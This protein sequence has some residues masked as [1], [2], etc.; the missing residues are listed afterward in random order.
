MKKILVALL[1]SACSITLWAKDTPS[2]KQQAAAGGIPRLFIENKGQIRDQNR[3]DRK[4]IRFSL[5]T[6][7]AT[8]LFIGK[9]ALH[10]QFTKAENGSAKTNDAN[11]T[12]KKEQLTIY[13]MDV[14]LLGAN[15][16]APIITEGPGNYYEQYYNEQSEPDGIKALSFKKVIYKN[17]YPHIDWVLYSGDG[18]VKYEFLVHPGANVSD[19]RLQYEGAVGLA[20]QEDGSLR[21][22]TPLGSVVEQA[23]VS[24][25]QDGSKIPTAFHLEG[26]LLTYTLG[27]FAGELVIDPVLE[28]STYYGDNGTEV[29]NSIATDQNNNIYFSGNTTSAANIATSGAFQ[30]SLSGIADA[31]LIKFDPAGTRLWGT[32]YGGS[33]NDYGLSVATDKA[34]NVYTCGG[35]VSTSGIASPGAH[36]TVAGGLQDAMVFKFDGSGKRIWSSYLGGAQDDQ[37]NE[38][39]ADPYGFI[40]LAG[41]TASSSAIATPGSYQASFAGGAR[42]AFIVRFDTSG[43]RIWGSYFGGSDIESAEALGCDSKGFACLGGATLSTS[44]IASAGAHQTA[45]GGGFTGDGF[46]AQFDTSGKR[47]WS[48]YYGGANG[49]TVYD[50]CCDGSDNIYLCGQTQSPSGIASGGAFKSVNNGYEAFLARFDKTGNRLWGTYYGDATSFRQEI[51]YGVYADALNNVYL[52][53]KTDSSTGLATTGAYQI[54]AGGNMDAF[55]ARFDSSGNRLW[56]TYFG[57]KSDDIAFCVTGDQ[58]G[59]VYIAGNTSSSTGIASSGAFKTTFGGAYD[60][61]LAKFCFEPKAGPIS[62]PADTVCRGLSIPIATKVPGGSWLS[63]TGKV[64]FS[65]GSLKGLSSGYDTILYV[66]SNNC[67]SDTTRKAIRI[68]DCTGGINETATD[69]QLLLLPNP[70]QDFARIQLSEKILQL[71]IRDISG[72]LLIEAMPGS[73]DAIIDVRSLVSGLYILHINGRISEK[74]LKE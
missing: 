9:T 67:G 63:K 31:C 10:Y 43:K 74:L 73:K 49:E 47:M 11:P 1:S 38:V 52:T 62:T 66:V 50:I 5:R 61:L 26:S 64:S 37:A 54:I 41:Y 40:Y 39:V 34:N 16:D 20:I 46:L 33:S 44:A 27:D 22:S 32:Y 14:Q 6:G 51:G 29:A 7:K 25:Q 19:I 55:L 12:N 15:E 36:Q 30:T 56:G 57:A 48:T 42:D 59:N 23:P 8:N 45:Y 13:R 17:I 21:A 68:T 71:Q 72:R 4:D 53:G 18:P 58:K 35:T 24:W 60:V 28:W 3:E 70:V 65:S 2:T 69:Y